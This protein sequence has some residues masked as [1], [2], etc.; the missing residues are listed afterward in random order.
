MN[1]IPLL[2]T[3]AIDMIGSMANI[4]FSFLATYYAYKL[5][6]KQP[7]NFLWSYLF[8]VTLAIAAFCISR[9]AG[10]LL[11]NILYVL[12]N[13]DLWK[14]FAPYS[15]GFNTLCMISVSA[16]MIF[17]HQ[18]VQAYEAVE[19]KAAKLQ[20]SKIR[21][22]RA[23]RALKELNLHLEE[24]VEERTA[25]LSES[26]KKFRHLFTASKDMVFFADTH[27]AIVEM[28]PSGWEMLGYTHE[29]IAALSLTRIFKNEG[30]VATYASILERD[31]YLIDFEAEFAKKDGSVIDVL[32]SATALYDEKGAVIGSEGI[33]KD[34]TRLK[35]M[36]EQLVSSE[37]MASVGQMAAGVAHEINTPL[38]VILGYAQLMMDDFDPDSE[39]YQ[40][41]QVIERQTKA[42]RK[43]VADLLKYSRQSGSARENLDPNEIVSDVVAVTGHNLNL[44]HIDVHLELAEGIPTITGDAEKLRQV[45]MNLVNNAQQA[46]ESQKGGDL[47]FTTRYDAQRSR[48][49][50]EVRDTGKGI[51]EKIRARIFDPFFTTKPVGKGTGLGL[52]VSYGIIQEH[53]GV[54]EVESPVRMPDNTT[55]PGTLFRLVLPA[56]RENAVPSFNPA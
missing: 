46:M 42:S 13:R 40:N 56:V 50:I 30:D 55:V 38:G 26:E 44:N 28:N 22:A 48:V 9:A 29:E 31:G 23:A 14:I 18:G 16:V 34:L 21:L 35:T 52:S 1:S 4:V 53:G 25:E 24:K 10:H 49:F 41:L 7:D 15:G 8:Y 19:Q 43:I 39:I 37:K 3:I 47:Y 6:R 33:A 54:I 17:Y 5:T 2:P 27:H 11:K 45:V 12:G 32:L 20:Q 36:M 51:P